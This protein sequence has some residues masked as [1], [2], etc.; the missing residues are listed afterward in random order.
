[1]GDAERDF[2]T[3]QGGQVT[4][5]LF[6]VLEATVNSTEDALIGGGSYSPDSFPFQTCN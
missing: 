5:T 4:L 3:V 6:E 2:G 1:M